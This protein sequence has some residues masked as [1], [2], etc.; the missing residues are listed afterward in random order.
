MYW[1]KIFSYLFNIC[2]ITGPHFGPATN[3]VTSPAG[4]RLAAVIAFL[5]IGDSCSPLCSAIISVL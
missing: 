4:N 2:V 5:V 3:A 1:N